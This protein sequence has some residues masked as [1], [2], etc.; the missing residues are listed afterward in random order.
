MPADLEPQRPADAQALLWILEGQ[1]RDD[2]HESLRAQYKLKA[3]AADKTIEAAH[4]TLA[5]LAETGPPTGWALGAYLEIYRRALE[6]GEL[7]V[8]L[9]AVAKIEQPTDTPPAFPDPVPE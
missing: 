6:T 4:E 3:A 1:R 8:A 9:R 7:S 5:R 2:I